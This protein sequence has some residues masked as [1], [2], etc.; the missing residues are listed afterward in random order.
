MSVLNVDTIYLK[1]DYAHINV[2]KEITLNLCNQLT[3]WHF[4]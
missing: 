2:T 1:A 4:I 3:F